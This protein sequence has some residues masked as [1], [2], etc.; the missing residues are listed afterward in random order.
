MS[1]PATKRIDVVPSVAGSIWPTPAQLCLL[2][3]ALGSG[4]T[5]RAAWTEWQRT[6]NLAALDVSSW[7]LLPLAW[8]NL[9]A[10]GVADE[11]LA[12]CRG[13]HRY[14]WARNQQLL[15]VAARWT[16]AWQARGVPVVV[17]KG[18][19][20]A[21]GTYP[22]AGT[23]PMSDIDLLVPVERVQELAEELQA[24]GWRPQVSHPPWRDVSLETRPSFNWQRDAEQ[25]D[26]HWHVLHRC[27]HPDITRRFWERARPLALPGAATRQL[28]AEDQLLHVCSH[29][30]Q[31]S[32][33][34]PFRWLADAAWILRGAERAGFDWARVLAMA[35]L[36]GT[37]LPLRH[38]LDY[39]AAELQLP[40]PA[41]VLAALRGRRASWRERWEYRRT[42][43]PVRGN[44]WIRAWNLAGL[45]WRV[46]GTGAPWTRLARMRRF[47][48]VRWDSPDLAGVLRLALRKTFTGHRGTLKMDESDLVV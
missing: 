35:E 27:T 31:Y 46:G 23:R 29:G 47:L 8:R 13:F 11:V 15:R 7:N 19:A 44:R 38:G 39:A 42:T 21:A 14:Q 5:A 43:E 17:L 22:D 16:G 48:C 34:P 18:A 32:P 25:L 37:A 28:A 33:Q 6:E 1:V 20:L 12:E 40:V 10:L 26:L 45:L 4:D 30:V 41:P 2:R 9:T 36:T 3:A 24:A